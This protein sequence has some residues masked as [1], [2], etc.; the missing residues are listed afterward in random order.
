VRGKAR[1][2]KSEL[3]FAESVSVNISLELGL[4]VASH[5]VGDVSLKTLFF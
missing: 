5:A 1:K 2:T 4:G 3:V